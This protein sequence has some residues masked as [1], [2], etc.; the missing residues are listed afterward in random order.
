LGLYGGTLA[1]RSGLS[2]LVSGWRRKRQRTPVETRVPEA[3]HRDI[4]LDDRAQY[5][6]SGEER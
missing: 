5:V 3:M 4:E 1:G 2:G 6:L